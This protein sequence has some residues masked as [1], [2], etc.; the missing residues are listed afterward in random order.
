MLIG[1]FDIADSHAA[2]VTPIYKGAHVFFTEGQF[3]PTT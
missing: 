2:A 1:D 3:S